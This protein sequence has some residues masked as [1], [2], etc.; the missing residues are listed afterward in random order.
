MLIVA[1][2]GCFIAACQPGYGPHWQDREVT[3]VFAVT[4]NSVSTA[5]QGHVYPQT[6]F[7][8]GVDEGLSFDK[9]NVR[10][11]I[12]ADAVWA[13][14]DVVVELYDGPRDTIGHPSACI[15]GWV[16]PP[17]QPDGSLGIVESHS[18]EGRRPSWAVIEFWDYAGITI[19]ELLGHD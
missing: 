18:L 13:H 14:D 17:P 2:V 4:H 7:V 1:G 19:L 5:F 16:V 8:L 3:P 12:N 15:T 9:P 11:T 6:R 10:L